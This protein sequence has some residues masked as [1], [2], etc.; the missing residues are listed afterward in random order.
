MVLIYKEFELWTNRS[1][2]QSRSYQSRCRDHQRLKARTDKPRPTMKEMSSSTT[3]PSN[4][5]LGIYPK[6]ILHP[7]ARTHRHQIILVCKTR[8]HSC[9]SRTL[10]K[11]LNGSRMWIYFQGWEASVIKR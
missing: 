11:T 4:Q 1:L 6:A 7:P 10:S 5:K 3:S 2:C 8:Q 9:N